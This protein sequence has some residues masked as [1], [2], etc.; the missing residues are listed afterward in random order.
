M[1]GEGETEPPPPGEAEEQVAT[2]AESTLPEDTLTTTMAGGLNPLTGEVSSLPP[3]MSSVR[4]SETV[5]PVGEPWVSLPPILP[6]EL[7][8]Y[9]YLWYAFRKAQ[10]FV[11]LSPPRRHLTHLHL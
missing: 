2:S 4:V 8:L 6:G 3:E 10:I 11:S 1:E 7:W 9:R 5:V